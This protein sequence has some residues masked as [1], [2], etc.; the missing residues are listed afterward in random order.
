MLGCDVTKI[1]FLSTPSVV[2][3]SQPLLKIRISLG[4]LTYSY[5]QFCNNF[6]MLSRHSWFSEP[7]ILTFFTLTIGSFHTASRQALLASALHSEVFRSNDAPC[8]LYNIQTFIVSSIYILLLSVLLAT[9]TGN[10]LAF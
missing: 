6:K 10:L 9:N 3:P 8:R 5:L 4:R 7:H 2:G 1:G